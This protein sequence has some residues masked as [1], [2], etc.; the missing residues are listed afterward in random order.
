MNSQPV[1][2]SGIGVHQPDL[3]L[4]NEWFNGTLSRK[5]V[6]HTG[7]QT[8]RISW[9]DEITMGRRAVEALQA[10]TDC[11][12][13]DCAG[14]VVAVSSLMQSRSADEQQWPG[15]ANHSER[16]RIVA[17]LL[18]QRLD[19]SARHVFGIN[20]GC[21]GYPRA[22]EIAR[23]FVLPAVDLR[24]D[25]F[26][27]VVTINRTSRIIDFGCKNTGAIFGDMAQASLLARVD[28]RRYPVRFAL[29]YAAAESRPVG[30]VM[31][32]FHLR[33]NVLAPTPDGGRATLPHR[34]VLFMDMMGIGDAAPRAMAS[35]TADAL[36]RTHISPD[37]VDYIVP[38]QAG[39]A[40]VNLAAMKLD[41]FHVRGE[42]LNGFTRDVG[43]IS[44]SSVPFVLQQMWHRL[45]GIIV[46]PTA[47]VGK[48]GHASL[49][50]GCV[51]LR[52]IESL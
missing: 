13:R 21:S 51:V 10:Q 52:S 30:S 29:E 42:L 23:R 49:S 46:C 47:G 39:V 43:N 4:G 20:W 12:L 25:Q 40:V 15:V 31:F 34:S 28:S 44:S 1:G 32:D 6:A 19:I 22:L 16:A 26:I 41:E 8:R 7:I 18:A 3:V 36:R 24:D 11:D 45:H 9:D 5:F 17:C 14:M 38:H 48:A 27:L 37:D 50:Q 2:I 35:A 33:E